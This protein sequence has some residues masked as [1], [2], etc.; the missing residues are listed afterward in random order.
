[1]SDPA[2]NAGLVV[3]RPLERDVHL[4]RDHP[5]DPL[6]LGRRD[7]VGVDRSRAL[8]LVE[9]VDRPCRLGPPGLL[10]GELAGVPGAH[11]GRGG[12]GG[13]GALDRAA[14]RDVTGDERPPGP[15]GEPLARHGVQRRRSVALRAARPA[16]RAPVGAATGPP[17]AG[18]AGPVPG[19]RRQPVLAG[20]P[21]RPVRGRAA[22]AWLAAPGTRAAASAGQPAE[23]VALAGHAALAGGGLGPGLGSVH[24]LLV[25]PAQLRRDDVAQQHRVHRL[26]HVGVDEHLLPV[27]DLDDD[28]ERRRLLAFQHALLGSP[29]ARL[30][31]AQGHAL[32]PADQVGERGVE[33]QVVE[34]VAVGRA[35]ELHA[36]FRDRAG[37]LRLQLRPDLVDDDDLG[38][39][40]LDR[41]DHHLVLEAG[42]AHLHPAGLADGRVRDVAVARD[43]VGRVHDHDALALLVGEDAGG[44]AEHGGLADAGPAHDQDRLPGLHEVRDDLD[45]PVDGATDA[46]GEADDLPA[47]VADRADPVERALDA[48]A[49]VVAEAPDVLHHV[50][51][52]GVGDLTLEE[53][54]LA[55]RIA[56]LGLP[57]EVEDDL[58][59]GRAVGQGRDRLDDLRRQRREED[60][61]IVGGCLLPVR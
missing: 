19:P 60:V 56:G 58:D 37:C 16:I 36:A 20:V 21:T 12:R 59:Q 51:D 22:P 10:A 38:H 41:L 35:D 49:V 44:L 40:V 8:L 48:G 14:V 52:V 45:R 4:A 17:P 9:R 26:G 42:R 24:A 32:D 15:H 29:A 57:A 55:R 54:D 34:V 7:R 30:L 1:M 46:A 2:P 31:V 6:L 50:R 28:V 47:A 39:V 13:L 61:E 25:P 18:L 3:V 33:H 23:P 11:L 53:R 43:L 27:L 5:R